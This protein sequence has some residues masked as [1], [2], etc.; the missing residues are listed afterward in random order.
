MD[1]DTREKFKREIDDM[2]SNAVHNEEIALDLQKRADE[3]RAWMERLSEA[4]SSSR[5]RRG[6]AE[7]A[8]MEAQIAELEEEA[9]RIRAVVKALWIKIHDMQEEER[10]L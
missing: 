8:D 4:G 10:N 5:V 7:A 9:A 6:K 3:K 1:D 2:I